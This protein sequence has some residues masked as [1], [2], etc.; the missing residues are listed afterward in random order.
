MDFIVP[1]VE[2]EEQGVAHAYSVVDNTDGRLRSG[3]FG[4]VEIE[5]SRADG[6][7]VVPEEAIITDGAERY[8]FVEIEEGAYR[9]QNLV[10]GARDGGLVEV[11]EGLYPG[12][13][14]VTT[15]NH[16]LASFFVRGVLELS[17]EAKRNIGFQLGEVEVRTLNDVVNVNG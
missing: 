6:A 13:R 5:V 8:S 14:V 1:I 10:L 2:V 16:E 9:L 17:E 4:R 7:F 12:D 3:Q 11:R 15:G